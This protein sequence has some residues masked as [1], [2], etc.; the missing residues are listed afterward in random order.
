MTEPSINFPDWKAPS[1]D[2]QIL[3]WPEPKQL[4]ADTR[5]NQA[6]LNS[7]DRVLIQNAPLPK[8]RRAMREFLGHPDDR[9]PL[10]GTGHQ[11]E[12]YHAGV[13]V[14]DVLIDQ[15]ARKIDGQA[16]HFAVD[17]DSPKHLN[18]RWP[19]A[20]FPVTDDPRLSSAAWSGGLAPPTPEHLQRIDETANRD[21]ASFGFRPALLDFLASLRR[22]SLESAHLS[23]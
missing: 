9:Q 7:S 22:L 11:T 17:T 4:L 23:S 16:F 3:I 5:A 20:S 13:W 18:I 8:L 12:L 6:L 2:G 15:A 21:F 19:G 1:D 14:K 10:L